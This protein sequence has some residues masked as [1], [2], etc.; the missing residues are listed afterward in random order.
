MLTLNT[1]THKYTV[2]FVVVC[3]R[4]FLMY[5]VVVFLDRFVFFCVLFNIVVSASRVSRVICEKSLFTDLNTHIYPPKIIY[6]IFAAQLLAFL[7]LIFFFLLSC[8]V[9]FCFF[10]TVAGSGCKCLSKIPFSWNLCSR[11]LSWLNAKLC[12]YN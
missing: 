5:C 8:C 4:C 11:G 1:H 3:H 2:D 6:Y 7:F 10:L 9:C 12:E